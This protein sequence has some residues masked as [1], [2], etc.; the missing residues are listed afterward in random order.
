M[1]NI[2][3]PINPLI[4]YLNDERTA[5]SN[6][7]LTD[8]TK[9]LHAAQGSMI[10]ELIA[11]R[12]TKNLSAILA[13]EHILLD[14][15]LT[16]YCNSKSMHNNL[17]EALEEISVTMK[18]SITVCSPEAYR[19]INSAFSLSENRVSGVPYDEARQS[20]KS[21]IIRLLNML[22]VRLDDSDKDLIRTRVKNLSSAWKIYIRLQKQA[23]GIIPKPE[24]LRMVN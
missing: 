23:L 22:K 20:F 3:H 12:R 17:T 14:N 13:A 11:I 5:F 16:H 9:L 2:Q 24:P 21:H 8:N 6:V 18:L 1:P 10:E 15:D 7:A 4:A 19:G